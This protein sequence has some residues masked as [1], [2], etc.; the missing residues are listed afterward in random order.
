MEKQAAIDVLKAVVGT[1][2]AFVAREIDERYRTDLHRKS[3][4]EPAIVLRPADSA[5]VAEILRIASSAALPVTALGGGTGLVG[6]AVAEEGGILV[7]LERLTSIEEIDVDS[8]TMTVAAGVTVEAALAAAA[9]RG[10]L[11]PLDLGARGSA[12]IG[13]TI[14]T[15]AGGTR[16]VRWGMMRDMVLGLEAVLAD[17]TIV[18]SMVKSLKDNA[19][20][21]WKQLMIGSEGTL[22]IVT[23]ALLRLRVTPRSSQTALLAARSVADIPQIFRIVDARLSGRLSSFELMWREFYRFVTSAQGRTPP[24]ADDAPLYILTEALGDA[25]GADSEAFHAVLQHL[26]ETSLVTDAVI[27]QSERERRQLWAIREDLLEPMARLKPRYSFDVSMG[28]ADLVRFAEGARDGLGAVL[29]GATVLI[30]GHGGDGN[31]HVTVGTHEAENGGELAS[32]AVYTATRAVGGSISAEHGIGRYKR[33]YIGF[34]RSTAE[35]SLMR[36][37]K[38]ALDPAGILNPGQI[39][40]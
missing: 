40:P 15:N 34:T 36:T 28:R 30:Y 6:G 38:D 33:P 7:S 26:L 37:I 31:L 9:A 27:A 24:I 2:H 4:S 23:R 1:G 39:L 14:A 21:D 10:L 29:P 11:L 32:E 13:G 25:D 5:Q 12:T 20:Y 35:L 19:G 16:V 17:G 3:R 22:G 8:M 18:S